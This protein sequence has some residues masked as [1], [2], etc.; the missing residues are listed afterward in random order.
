MTTTDPL[1]VL[2]RVTFFDSLSADEHRKLFALLQP[3]TF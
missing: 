1:Q 3:V 2:R